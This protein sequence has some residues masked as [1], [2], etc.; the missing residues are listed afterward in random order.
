MGLNTLWTLDRCCITMV[1]VMFKTYAPIVYEHM[2]EVE[3]CLHRLV[4]CQLWELLIAPEAFTHTHTH[5]N[6]NN[7]CIALIVVN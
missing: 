3:S 1:V 4:C 2:F 7:V 5:L 6:L